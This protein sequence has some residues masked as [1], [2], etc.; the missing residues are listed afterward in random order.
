MSDR[1]RAHI[2]V[3]GDVQ[4]VSFRAAAVDEARRLRVHGWVR[5]IADGR[6]E[7]PLGCIAKG[8]ACTWFLTPSNPATARK[9]RRRDAPNRLRSWPARPVRNGTSPGTQV[10]PAVAGLL[11]SPTVLRRMALRQSGSQVQDAREAA[12]QWVK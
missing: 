10:L 1:A 11:I 9:W 12:L 4:G 7:N 2:L 8:G 3:S 5:N 6:V